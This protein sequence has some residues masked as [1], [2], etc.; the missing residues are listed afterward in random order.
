M[1]MHLL[2][3]FFKLLNIIKYYL[4]LIKLKL[5]IKKAYS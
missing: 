1:Q 4:I 3:I 5:L 2:C